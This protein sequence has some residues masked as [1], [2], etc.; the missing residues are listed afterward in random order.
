VRNE[1]EKDVGAKRIHLLKTDSFSSF[2][3]LIA[4]LLTCSVRRIKNEFQLSINNKNIPAYFILN[5]W[6]FTLRNRMQQ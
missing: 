2:R 4:G 6:K 5:V 1:R 3:F